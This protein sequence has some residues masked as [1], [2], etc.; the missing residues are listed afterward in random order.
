MSADRVAEALAA[1]EAAEKGATP[2][3]W[4]WGWSDDITKP[5]TALFDPGSGDQ[6]CPL[7]SYTITPGIGATNRTKGGY[8]DALFIARWRNAAPALKHVAEMLDLLTSPKR[9]HLDGCGECVWCRSRAALAELA[10][11][12]LGP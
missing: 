4:E 6:V 5:P 8:E 7:D 11:A 12:V 9:I 10:E 1:L 2:G 3:P